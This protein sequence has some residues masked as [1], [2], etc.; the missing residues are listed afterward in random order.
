MEGDTFIA[1]FK[2]TKLRDTNEE[3]NACVFYNNSVGE[4]K[5]ECN[6]A[7]V[8]RECINCNPG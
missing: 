3:N 4:V 8:K 5:E 1:Y 7:Y 2:A 6:P